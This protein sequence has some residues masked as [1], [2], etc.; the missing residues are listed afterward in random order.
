MSFLKDFFNKK[1]SLDTSNK[2]YDKTISNLSKQAILD[3]QTSEKNLH[4][5]EMESITSNVE[6]NPT[7]M[8]VDSNSQ[9]NIE[10]S[11]I[12][13]SVEETQAT[14]ITDT[15]NIDSNSNA[16]NSNK[17]NLFYN[18]KSFIINKLNMASEFLE[19][20]FIKEPLVY[21]LA[22]ESN[23]ACKFNEMRLTFS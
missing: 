7:N 17:K 11:D 15:S 2:A 21:S 1:D 5:S 9:S 6:M 19:T 3:S 12:E 22:Y 4:T 20:L 10:S 16:K 8:N 18:L 13:S 14:L 23:I